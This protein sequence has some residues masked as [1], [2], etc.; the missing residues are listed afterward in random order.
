[1]FS[2]VPYNLN[3][4]SDATNHVTIGDVTG[5][6]KLLVPGRA[7]AATSIPQGAITSPIE[8]ELLRGRSDV[9]QTHQIML[10]EQTG[11]W[12]K[13]SQGDL[14]QSIFNTT[15]PFH[16]KIVKSPP[17]GYLNKKGSKGTDD[18]RDSAHIMIDVDSTGHIESNDASKQVWCK[19]IHWI[20]A[21]R[22]SDDCHSYNTQLKLQ[23]SSSKTCSS[24]KL[25]LQAVKPISL[26]QE[27]L[28]WFS[29]EILTMLQ[30]VFLTPANIQ[31]Q[32]KYV[33]THCSALYESPNPLKLHITLGCGKQTITDLWERLANLL[34]E[35]TKNII[36]NYSEPTEF[37]F[38][39]TPEVCT[40]QQRKA[41]DLST[42]ISGTL[43]IKRPVSQPSHLVNCQTSSLSDENSRILYRPYTEPPTTRNSAFRPFQKIDSENQT[44]PSF[45]L[46]NL[47]NAQVSWSNMTFNQNLFSQNYLH[48]NGGAFNDEAQIETLMSTLGKSKEG[49]ICLYCGKC[50]SRKYGLKIHIRTH[51][52]YKPLKCK[53]CLR[54]FGDPSNLNKHVRL[55]AE[56]ETPYKCELCGK[57]LVRRRDLERHLKSRHMGD[58]LPGRSIVEEQNTSDITDE[59]TQELEVNR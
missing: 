18:D 13:N 41:M 22:L 30:M 24:S 58:I 38:E 49:H 7:T 31:G 40:N 45:L 19:N 55:H 27:L 37:T 9:V 12:K 4:R 10:I 5:S 17:P 15:H 50:Y 43:E 21:L 54:P 1:M 48:N 36:S 29:D 28:L 35:D 32:K 20:R 44:Q 56:G 53:F 47:P 2:M 25:I 39:L 57:I 11:I 59:D 16:G 6:T 3:L 42:P 33:C 34:K 26:G 8:P 52:G 51:T 14:L 23:T 46:H